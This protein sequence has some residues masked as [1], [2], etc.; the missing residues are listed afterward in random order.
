MIDLLVD[1][2]VWA[3]FLALS[4][5]EIVLGIDNVIFLSIVA[6]RLP[7]A[8]QASARR[9]GLLLALVMRVIF[10]LAIS[11]I[12]GLTQAAFEVFGHAVSWRDLVLIAGGLFLLVKGT[13]EIHASVEGGNGEGGTHASPT[14]AAAGAGF[15][16]VVAQIVMLDLVFSIDSVVT[17]VGMVPHVEVMIAA[18]VVAI[19]VMMAAAEPV[20]RFI[21]AHPTVKMLA[22]AFLLLVGVALVADGLHFHIP[23]GYI[24]FAIAFSAGVEG[25][26]LLA[27]RRR[28]RAGGKG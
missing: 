26:N 22:L 3:S 4:A 2:S 7:P 28:E 15:A 1:P 20:S 23:R 14:Q 18:V 11:W 8:R 5:L 6:G 13:L 25:L 12:I 27:R 17:A 16:L 10:L 24:Y 21:E 9:I 19:A